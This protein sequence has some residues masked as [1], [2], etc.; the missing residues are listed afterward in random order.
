MRRWREGGERRGRHLKVG[1]FQSHLQ[2]KGSDGGWCQLLLAL[3][4]HHLSRTSL[5]TPIQPRS[6]APGPLAL[7]HP[8]QVVGL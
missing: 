2:Q 4:L 1:G 8:V 5:S 6:V 3:P 7:L